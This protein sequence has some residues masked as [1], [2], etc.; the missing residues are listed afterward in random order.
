MD[1]APA[2]LLVGTIAGLAGAGGMWLFTRGQG[3]A[4]LL[5]PPSP[6]AVET[7]KG[8]VG[9]PEAYRPAAGFEPQNLPPIASGP[10]PSAARAKSL[11]TPY[12]N[13]VEDEDVVK[14]EHDA[15]TVRNTNFA[16]LPAFPQE[17][18]TQNLSA[19]LSPSPSVLTPPKPVDQK[20]FAE[21]LRLVLRA[22]KPYIKEGFSF[23]EDYWG[24]NLESSGKAVTQQLF[25]GNEYWFIAA[26]DG[27]AEGIELHVY[28]S[29]GNLAEAEHWLR[30][31]TAGARVEPKRA[32]TY[33]II[34]SKPLKKMPS[35]QT[36]ASSQVAHWV[37]T[38]GYR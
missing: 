15:R 25:R 35:P 7:G 11:K 22:Q 21:A 23:R 26:T 13:V 12:I 3:G 37:V 27:G 8:R 16:A 31:E 33:Y 32:G 28:D 5:H 6:T 30:S 9:V 19:S 29:D 24:G 1:R 36:R 18:R 2:L 4:R 17:R 20:E 38:Y 10:P 34:V 14:S